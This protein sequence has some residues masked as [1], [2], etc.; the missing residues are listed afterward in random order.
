MLATADLGEFLVDKFVDIFSS[1]YVEAI[2]GKLGFSH[3]W[4]AINAALVG[5]N[6]LSNELALY[7][8]IQ[9]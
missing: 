1:P 2:T 5:K 7:C 9:L 3:Q 6:N 4:G 8:F